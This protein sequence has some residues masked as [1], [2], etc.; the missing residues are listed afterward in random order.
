MAYFS[1]G[2]NQDLL[3]LPFDSQESVDAVFDALHKNF[4]VERVWWRG[5]QDE[6][7]GKHFALREENRQFAR[8]WQW[9]KHLAYE[10]VGTNRLAVRAAH[11]RGQKIWLAYGLFDH[12]S[13]A[14][15]GY[16]GFPY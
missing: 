7:W 1:T 13:A 5:G 12:G 15:V 10:N 6:I 9:W 16:V 2:D 4:R 14:D 11:Q 3:W 8:I